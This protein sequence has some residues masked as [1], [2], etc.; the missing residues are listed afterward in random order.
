MGRRPVRA[1][2]EARLDQGKSRGKA[3]GKTKGKAQ[4]VNPGS[5]TLG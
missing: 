4:G 5:S 1:K 2:D 3:R